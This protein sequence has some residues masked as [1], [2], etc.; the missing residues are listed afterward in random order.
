VSGHHVDYEKHGRTY[1]VHRRPDPRIAAR[2][3]AALG[4]ARTVLNVGAGTGSYETNDRWVLAVVRLCALSAGV[5]RLRRSPPGRRRF[6]LMT[7]QSTLQWLASRSTTGSRPGPGWQSC[8]AWRA[9]RSSSSRSNLTS[10]PHGSGSSSPKG[11]RSSERGFRQSTRSWSRLV[12][13][14]PSRAHPDA[15]GLHGW[16]LRG[17]LAAT[18]GST[19]RGGPRRPIDVGDA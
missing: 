3:H 4:D 7:T 19:R 1:A 17:V 6:R 8:V 13:T 10:F 18:R 5:T 16:V 12:A 15:V 2:I 11:S 9:D 14:H